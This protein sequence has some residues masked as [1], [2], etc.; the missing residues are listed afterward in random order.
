V[1]ADRRVEDER[2]E[3]GDQS[4]RC[5]RHQV[6][7]AVVVQQVSD[8]VVAGSEMLGDVHG[9]LLGGSALSVCPTLEPLDYFS[10]P[11]D[12]HRFARH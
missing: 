2:Q 7:G 3:G 10:S 9:H 6:G 1:F 5:R 4:V 8:V 11:D 12:K